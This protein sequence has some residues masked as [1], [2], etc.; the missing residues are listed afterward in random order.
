M[1]EEILE[2][3]NKFKQYEKDSI[4][5]KTFTEG[6]CYYF[7]LILKE[8]FDG[9]IVYIKEFDHFVLKKDEFL[10]DITGNVSKKYKDCKIV[11]NWKNNSTIIKQCILK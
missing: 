2:F 8:R 6:F 1:K 7:A 9:E 4:L 10:F 11:V 3:I 5:V